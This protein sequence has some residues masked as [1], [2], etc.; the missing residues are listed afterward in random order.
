MFF[1]VLQA[2]IEDLFH[3][4]RFISQQL[5]LFSEALINCGTNRC[6]ENGQS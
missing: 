6:L 5:P 1:E 4:E 3:P 2:G